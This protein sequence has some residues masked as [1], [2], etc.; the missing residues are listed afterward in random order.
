MRVINLTCYIYMHT[1]LSV[2]P[3]G[4]NISSYGFK[5]SVLLSNILFFFFLNFNPN[6][7]KTKSLQN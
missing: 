1:Q 6:N 2:M 7:S 3:H 5:R 4:S